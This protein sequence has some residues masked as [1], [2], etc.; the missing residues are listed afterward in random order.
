MITIRNVAWNKN[1]TGS[2]ACEVIGFAPKRKGYVLRASDDGHL[3]VFTPTAL[4]LGE[5][6]ATARNLL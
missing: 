1:A 5:M 4:A 2:T 3:Y 6:S